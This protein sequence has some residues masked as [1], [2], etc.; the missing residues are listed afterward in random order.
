MHTFLNRSK[1]FVVFM[2][3]SSRNLRYTSCI[4]REKQS[5]NSK[6]SKHGWR[7]KPAELLVHYEFIVEGNIYQINLT[8]SA[9][10]MVLKNNLTLPRFFNKME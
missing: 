1:F 3:D 8:L 4:P 5:H 9:L 7:M 10:T 2:D 6:N